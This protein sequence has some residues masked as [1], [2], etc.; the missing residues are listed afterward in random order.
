MSDGGCNAFLASEVQRHDAH[1]IQR[2][3]NLTYSLL[4]SYATCYGAVHLVGQPIL[5]GHCFKLKYF[6]EV[7][8]EE[9]F[10]VRGVCKGR[11]FLSHIFKNSFWRRAK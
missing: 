11:S 2:E 8:K 10:L 6:F 3:L 7:G 5:T 1:I 4:G 9:A